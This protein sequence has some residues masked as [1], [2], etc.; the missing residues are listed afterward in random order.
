M[1]LK[2]NRTKFVVKSLAPIVLSQKFEFVEWLLLMF[3][4]KT[5]LSEICTPRGLD[6]AP[7]TRHPMLPFNRCRSVACY[8]HHL[9][10]LNWFPFLVLGSIVRIFII[11]FHSKILFIRL[12]VHFHLSFVAYCLE[13][14]FLF[15]G[16]GAQDYSNFFLV[17]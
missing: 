10:S 15:V 16:G 5:C 13:N 2:L 12:F 6:L 9:S 11:C 7:D 17:G 3:T 8:F 14:V 4:G 1:D